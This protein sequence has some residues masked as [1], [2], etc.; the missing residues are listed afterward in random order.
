MDGLLSFLDMGGYAA[1]VWPC[2]A[3]AAVL[4]TWVFVGSHRELKQRERRMEQLRAL[5]PRRRRPDAG[6]EAAS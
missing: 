4:M 6:E 3:L 5:S 2:F 1:F